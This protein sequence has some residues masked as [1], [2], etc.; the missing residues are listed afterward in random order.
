[1]K[2]AHLHSLRG[3]M[4]CKGRLLHGGKIWGWLIALSRQ[5]CAQNSRILCICKYKQSQH[6]STGQDWL[7][8]APPQKKKNPE[9][10]SDLF[11]D[12][13]YYL[14]Q[15]PF[16]RQTKPHFLLPLFRVETSCHN[17]R[18]T[19]TIKANTYLS[20]R[21]FCRSAVAEKNEDGLTSLQQ[22]WFSI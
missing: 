21:I 12:H 19:N 20:C 9:E 4:F 11:T 6:S 15:Q 8:Y 10:Q 7:R 14:C 17:R 13:L 3:G 16:V 5:R 22:I 1:M 18:P 2:V